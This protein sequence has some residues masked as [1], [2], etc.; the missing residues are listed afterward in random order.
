[1]VK[2]GARPAD[3]DEADEADEPD[4]A[5]G[6]APP[7]HPKAASVPSRIPEVRMARLE[8]MEPSRTGTLA[9]TGRSPPGLRTGAGDMVTSR[10]DPVR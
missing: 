7:P 9:W 10:W 5:D 3:V 2:A 1:M 6:V 8:N 4:G